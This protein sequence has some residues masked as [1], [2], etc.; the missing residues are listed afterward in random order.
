[1]I[2]KF[3]GIS[4]GS[5]VGCALISGAALWA[6]SASQ[7]HVALGTPSRASYAA[8]PA[9]QAM[10]ALPGPLSREQ[11]E[12]VE[13]HAFISALSEPLSTFAVDVDTASYAN[14]RR[15]L[16]QG[17]LPPS[18]AVRVE[19]L[20][21][22]FEYDYPEPRAGEPVAIYSEVGDCPWNAA[23]KLLHVGVRAR[24][25]ASERVPPRNLVFLLDVS[26][27][28]EDEDKLPL[29]KKAFAA[30]TGQLRREDKVA[31]VVYAGSEGLA[32][33]L[34]SG[35]DKA[36][37][38]DA[39]DQLSAGGSTNGGAGIELAYRVAQEGFVRG[40]INRVI[41]ATDG[42]FNVG[43]TSQGELVSLIERERESGVF[44]TVL[45]FG[46]GNLQDHTMESLA[47][48]G[49]G[50]YAYLDSLREAEKVLVREAGS[51]LVTVAR[52]VKVQ[53]ELNP[54]QVAQY[55]LVGY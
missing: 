30:L 49:N 55:R 2:R 11:Y 18:A 35:A 16:T 13:E 28:M 4:Y 31:I 39:L 17:T 43:T 5:L 36:H 54:A 48:H 45:G 38:L 1:M 26:G 32:L 41:L 15:F 29:L 9:S 22:Y 40:G 46:S 8:A 34:T 19:E 14:V 12:H 33:P 23:H 6:C 25:L 37:I 42:D 24:S 20:L 52:D 21:N 3:R 44:L 53:V 27:S 51:T 7:P 10:E 50:N 47:A